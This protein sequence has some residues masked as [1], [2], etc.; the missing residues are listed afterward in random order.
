MSFGTFVSTSKLLGSS[1]EGPWDYS[2]RTPRRG[3]FFSGRDIR[4]PAMTTLTIMKG[5]MLQCL[6]ACSATV[7]VIE[8]FLMSFERPFKRLCKAF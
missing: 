6:A 1:S 8:G 7:Q 2:G 3:H 5:M 4:P